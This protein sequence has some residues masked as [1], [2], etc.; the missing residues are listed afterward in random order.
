MRLAPDG[1]SAFAVAD[2]PMI[3]AAGAG[4][5]DGVAESLGVFNRAKGLRLRLEADKRQITLCE[6]MP[7]GRIMTAFMLHSLLGWG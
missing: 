7:T 4:I 1:E 3:G 5:G 2:D 6:R